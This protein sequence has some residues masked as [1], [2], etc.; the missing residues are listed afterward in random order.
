[1]NQHS[2]PRRHAPLTAFVGVLV[3]TAVGAVLFIGVLLPRLGGGTPYVILTGSM[4]PGMPPGTLVVTRPVEASRI[5]IGTVVTY[6]LVSGEPTVVTHRV[7]A[8]GVNTV[9][10]PVFRTRGDANSAVDPGW[11]RGVQVRGERWYDV[12]YLGYVTSLVGTRQRDLA[13]TL[14]VAF[15]LAYA[16][17][18][19]TTGLRDRRSVAVGR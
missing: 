6:Q 9:G 14:V 12:P 16:A 2:K 8:Q 3:I 10:E 17:A 7:V 5:G 18:M 11:V 1:M 13:Q 19:I 15:L 4:R